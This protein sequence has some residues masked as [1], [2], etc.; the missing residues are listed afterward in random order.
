MIR[1]R[2][3][4]LSIALAVSVVC[5]AG[6]QGADRLG[7]LLKRIT[8]EDMAVRGPAFQQI[9]KMGPRGVRRVA[10]RLLEPGKLS[11]AGAR[12]AL[13]GLAHRVIRPDAEAARAA[14]VKAMLAQ[15]EREQRTEVKRFLIRQLQITGREDA[16]PSLARYLADARF[17]ETA[18]QA[19]AANPT[20]AALAALRNALRRAKGMERVGIID[21][22]GFRR[23]AEALR[24]LIA[25]A[26][27]RDQAA[28]MAAYRALGRIGDPKAESTLAAA[29][30]K[31]KPRERR[32]A[33]DGYLLLAEQLA[34]ADKRADGLRIYQRVLDVAPSSAL[35]CAAL[36][37]IG[38]AGPAE[39]LESVLASMADVDPA[40]RYAARSCLS[41]VPDAKLAQATATAMKSAQP[42]VR[43]GLLRLLD[44][45][46]DPKAKAT[47]ET[48]MKD[49]SAE[50]RVTAADLLK[51]LDEPALEPTLLEAAEKGS[52]AV[53]AVAL[54]AYIGRAGARLRAGEKDRALAMFNRALELARDD[55]L[56]REAV[57]GMASVASIDL[58]PK[59]EQLLKDEAVR[60]EAIRAYVAIADKIAAKG[61]KKR[62]IKMLEDSLAMGP[63]RDV[64]QDAVQK[65]YKLGVKVDPA[66]R[67]GFVTTW[68]IIGPFPGH[69]IDKKWPPEDGVDLAASIKAGDKELKWTKHHT[70]DAQGVVNLA[71]LMKPNQNVT[72]YLYA[73]VTVDR[74]QEVIFRSGSDD[75][76]IVW[77]NAERIFRYGSPRSLSVDQDTYRAR[78]QAGTNR[79]LVKI[80]N[81]GGGWDGCVRLQDTEGKAL[82]FQQKEE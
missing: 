55:G 13:H 50:V 15:L 69:D 61:D 73:E 81:G 49:P 53:H 42:K 78:L 59:V 45:R 52:N 33:F 65:L 7:E 3:L 28:R 6:E 34:A 63:P 27:G 38:K 80:E 58:L 77:L 41:Q 72:A 30:T 39:A 2:Y 66:H 29:T 67:S 71:R 44:E 5:W 68:W 57:R 21:A 11:D 25:E 76:M 64:A 70:T 32:A 1:R 24:A 26:A 20:P 79:L 60:G 35:R 4:V 82:K 46:K 17:A 43:A 10:D 51:K 54:K 74:A 16:V 23:D 9:A 37:G 19:L 18:R 56:R 62:G 31:G 8:S 48:A 22:L 47:I 14:F 40:V 36:V 12:F 75:G